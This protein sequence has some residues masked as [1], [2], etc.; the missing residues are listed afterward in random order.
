MSVVTFCFYGWDKS[1][2]KKQQQRTPEKT[3]H[4][5]SL[6][7]GWPGALLGQKLFRHKT[8]KTR[9]RVVFWLTLML[10]LLVLGVLCFFLEG[11]TLQEVLK[12]M[13]DIWSWL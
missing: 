3:L 10:N 9:F 13:R 6:T 12:A 7:G 2:A 5:L 11:G 8:K 4:W 1:A